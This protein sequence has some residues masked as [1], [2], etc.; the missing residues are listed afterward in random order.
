MVC[1]YYLLVKRVD[2]LALRVFQHYYDELCQAMK[3]SLKEVATVLYSKKLVTRQERDQ[4]LHAQGLTPMRKTDV[5]MQAIARKIVAANSA[6][7][8]RKF[9]RVLRRHH[10]VGSIVSRMKAR[11]G[12]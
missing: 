5:L 11:L 3:N 8:L 10:V 12:D 9:C 2:S 7:P 4:A 1:L 6:T